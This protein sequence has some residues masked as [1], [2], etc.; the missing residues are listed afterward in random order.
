MKKVLCV[1][2]LVLLIPSLV[3]SEEFLPLNDFEKGF[4]GGWSMYAALSDGT[5]YHYTLTFTDDR[6]VY[7]RTLTVKDGDADYNTVSSGLYTQ[8][9]DDILLLSLS[10]KNFVASITDDDVLKLLDN[11]SMT[12]W[13]MFS[14]CPDMSYV[15]GK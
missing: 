9:M 10:G 3:C 11:S 14:R 6:S 4:V 8:F 1:F 13:G 2:L 12:L 5:V 7:L 15:F